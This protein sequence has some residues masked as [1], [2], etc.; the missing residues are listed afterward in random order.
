M[1]FN[2]IGK[3]G[4]KAGITS[5]ILSFCMFLSFATNGVAQ[6]EMQIKWEKT[7]EHKTD[8]V[9][10]GLE[11]PKEVSYI[12]TDKTITV[13][14]TSDGSVVWSK[15]FK[16]LAPKLRKIDELIPFWKSN[17]LFLFE[18][19]GGKDQ[20]AVID[21]R[22]GDLL[23]NTDRYSKLS[24]DNIVY[25]AEDDAF[26]MSLAGS[27][28]YVKARTGE[29][30]WETSQF[31]G[32]VGKYFYENGFITAINLS[33]SGLKGLFKGF[34]N[35]IAK[36]NLS[37]GDIVWET[38]YRG[39]AERKILTK[40][41]VYDF[42]KDG[43][44]IF[45]HLNGIQVFDYK[46]GA[47]LWSAAYDATPKVIGAPAGA[48][49]WGVYGAVADP[50]RVGN[51]VYVIEMSKKSDQKIKKYDYNTGKLLWTSPE[52]KKARALPNL[53]VVGDKVVV[54]IGGVVETHAIVRVKDSEGNITITR[55][56]AYKNVKP[57]GMQAFNTSD[58]SFAWA[59]EKFKKG[60]T[61][62]FVNGETVYV[63]SGKALYS[64]QAATGTENY[65][66]NTKA[67]GV[68][69]AVQILKHDDK[70][71]VIG[72]KGITTHKLSDGSLVNASKYKRSEMM[73][74]EG[75]IVIMETTKKDIACFDLNDCT[76]QEYNNKKS[77]S[78]VL[79][80]DGN[81]VYVYQKKNVIK[82]KTR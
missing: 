26:A 58:G 64:I 55:T 18:K 21:F 49:A 19:K 31:T 16:E 27:L 22:T 7:F 60:I 38:I 59:S 42:F 65:E 25:I 30:L 2:R 71:A 34:K 23:W 3:L 44:K 63:C 76:Y 70:I 14:K 62:A 48:I 50:V 11:G 80:Q 20:I 29:E 15:S 6:E 51:D 32:V 54:Q 75:N 77:A 35:Q 9:G 39:V 4:S 79:S 82:L 43:N 28:N 36:I 12:A 10:T 46:T 13:F 69:L 47:S 67:D 74:R 40:E 41:P 57:N 45:L 37:N 52:I 8:R 17:C 5:K 72:Q 33:P 61:N 78:S 68:G 24:E 1:N 56:I 53:F 73:R 81:F 66:V